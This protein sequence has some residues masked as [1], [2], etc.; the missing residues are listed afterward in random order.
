MRIGQLRFWSS[1][2]K[3]EHHQGNIP[4]NWFAS[5]PS[6]YIYICS[7]QLV[8]LSDRIDRT[9]NAHTHSPMIDVHYIFF[10]VE[11]LIYGNG[12]WWWWWWWWCLQTCITNYGLLINKPNKQK[13]TVLYLLTTPLKSWQWFMNLSNIEHIHNS[14]IK[15]RLVIQLIKQ[16][17]LW[18][19]FE[20]CIGL[21][22]QHHQHI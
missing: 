14:I 13:K 18:V 2:I 3:R 9:P 7:R 6:V 10:W 4:V 11:K 15:S 22:G 12:W 1:V 19:W 20:V 8:E 16:S 21:N 5:P 17:C